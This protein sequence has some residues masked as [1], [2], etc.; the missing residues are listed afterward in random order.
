MAVARN[1]AAQAKE[2]HAIT[3]HRQ[4]LPEPFDGWEAEFAK[5]TMQPGPGYAPHRHKGFVLGYVIDG[6]FRFGL[7]GQPERVLGAGEVFYEPPGALHT[8]SAS[9]S[10]TRAASILAIIISKR[11]ETVAQ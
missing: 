2:N 8:I 4:S 9:A 1:A 7:D 3:I 11:G 6:Q 10:N 5:V